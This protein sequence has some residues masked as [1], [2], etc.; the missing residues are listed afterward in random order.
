MRSK[1]GVVVV[2]LVFVLSSQGFAAVRFDGCTWYNSEDAKNLKLNEDGQLVWIPTLATQ[3]MVKL[4]ARDLSKVGDV[5]DVVYMFKAD[6][7]KTGVPGTDPTM[8]SG[9]GDLR[10]GLFDS[11][12]KG[13]VEK[14]G[15]GYRSDTWVGYLGYC[16][17][18]CPCLPV[19]IEREHSDAIPG[20]FMKR[21]KA[22]DP[23]VGPSLLQKAGPYGKSRDL[24]GFGLELGEWTK[25]I[26]RVERTAPSTLVYSV[27]MK[28][29][30]YLYIDDETD[31]QPKKIDAMAIYFPNP[32]NYTSF[33]FAGCHFSCKSS[34]DGEAKRTFICDKKKGTPAE[35]K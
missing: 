7:A 32:N 26:L 35:K 33:T 5:A 31:M 15:G 11:N 29:T 23:D 10:I 8:L 17:R 22:N 34:D 28:G 12:G 27:T 20:K 30:K 9:T 18:I 14:D 3:I 4:P 21:T 13:H 19:V 25:M 2:L 16:A 6:G 1:V 24:S